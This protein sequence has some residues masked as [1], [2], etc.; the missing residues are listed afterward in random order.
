MSPPSRRALVASVLGLLIATACAGPRPEAPA[1][2]ALLD[3]LRGHR[4]SVTSLAV[5]RDGQWIVSGSRDGTLRVWS[6]GGSGPAAILSYG[7]YRLAVWAVAVSPDG[8]LAAGGSDDFVVRVWDLQRRAVRTELTG[9]TQSI[10]VL[11]FSPD[12][13]A[14][15]SGGRDTTVRLWDTATWQTQAVLRHDDTVRGLAFSPDGRRLFTGTAAD[16]IHVWD[17][18]TGAQVTTLA[19]HGNTVHALAVT[20]DG[21]TL[22]SGAADRTLRLWPLAPTPSPSVLE[23]DRSGEPATRWERYGIHPGP[24]VMAVAA[25]PDGRLVASAHRDSAIRLWSLPEG[26]ELTRLVSPA[27]TTYSVAFSSDGRFLYSGG[28]DDAVH[29]WDLGAIT[30]AA[31]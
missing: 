9:H 3:S 20:P 18:T 15:A 11:A 29:R 1:P 24:E 19:G 23:L 7:W 4:N 10:R 17:V 22:V 27:R 12:G 8:A 21:R 26:V 25:S 6:N 2:G 30:S 28:D 13:R 16:L 5:S 31:R 14:L